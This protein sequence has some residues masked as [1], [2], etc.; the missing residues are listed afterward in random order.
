MYMCFYSYAEAQELYS[1]YTYPKAYPEAY[2]I[3]S[4]DVFTDIDDAEISPEAYVKALFKDR[5]AYTRKTLHKNGEVYFNFPLIEN[6]LNEVLTVILPDSLTRS[7][8]MVYV[9]RSA[10]PNAYSF[11][12]GSIYFNIGLLAELESTDAVALILGHELAHILNKDQSNSFQK[13]LAASGSSGS[14]KAMRINAMALHRNEQLELKADSMGLLLSTRSGYSCDSYEDIIDVLKS[15]AAAASNNSNTSKNSYPT[16]QKR[17]SL[18]NKMKEELSEVPLTDS[19]E[20]IRIQKIARYESLH[21][22]QKRNNH[23]EALMK[24][25]EYHQN[26]SDDSNYIYQAYENMRRLL[27]IYPELRSETFIFRNEESEESESGTKNSGSFLNRPNSTAVS[28]AELKRYLEVKALRTSIPEVLLTKALF[29]HQNTETQDRNSALNAYIKRKNAIY[30]DYAEYL[31]KPFSYLNGEKQDAVFI[32]ELTYL[33]KDKYGYRNEILDEKVEKSYLSSI[34]KMIRRKFKDKSVFLLN[35]LNSSSYNDAIR[36]KES[37]EDVRFLREILLN[38]NSSSVSH[39]FLLNPD[40]YNLYSRYGINSLEYIDIIAFD[41]QGHPDNKLV[42]TNPIN[43][44]KR[45]SYLYS[46]GST[47]HR[48]SIA[49]YAYEPY[50]ETKFNFYRSIVKYRL[51]KANLLNSVYQAL[52]QSDDE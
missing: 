47:K 45:L 30:I 12:D 19:E 7:N 52:N 51:T 14:D 9:A 24:A 28:Y 25:L 49:Y 29:H 44:I 20:H 26:D 40:H 11:E 37:L 33:K 5:S 6:Y 27:M 50:E 1:P 39:L 21:L 31:L 42:M 48:F 38:S 17:A 2:V 41:A 15:K 3:N 22:L 10:S 43:W 46:N 13:T 4:P 18:L 34:R 16:W 8:Y 35:D 32:N 23:E 36:I